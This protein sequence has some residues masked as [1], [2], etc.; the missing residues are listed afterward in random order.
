[1]KLLDNLIQIDREN[2]IS[3]F[4][5]TDEFF[6]AY[7]NK[8][9]N[10]SNRNILILT[11]TLYESNKIFSSIKN[12][13]D[14]A[15]FF[16][17]DDFLTNESIAMSPELKATR[18]DTISNLVKDKKSIVV[19]HLES[20]L[21]FLPSKKIFIDSIIKISVGDTYLRNDIVDKL[22]SIGYV[23][24]TIVTNTGEI[25]IRGFVIDV[26][27]TNMEYPIRIEFFDDI[28]ESIK[29]FNPETQK[30]IETIDTIEILPNTEFIR[31]SD[32]ANISE[33]SQKYLPEYCSD[34]SN[35]L[36]YMD[37]SIIV[38]KDKHQINSAYKKKCEEILEYRS[39]KDSNFKGR[40]M[41]ELSDFNL[42]N[43]ILY[44]TLDNKFVN[45]EHILSINYGVKKVPE[46]HENI[47]KINAYLEAQLLKK[48]TI[49]ICLKEFQVRSFTK[50]LSHKYILTDD[51]NI[52][53]ESINIINFPIQE[54][55]IY[56][57]YVFIT[58]KELFNK[59]ENVKYKQ[60][61][62]YTSKIKSINNIEIGDYVVHS[63]Y[64]ISVYNGIKTLTKQ[65]IKKDYLELLYAGT[66][67]LY[68]PVE[69]IEL[70]GKYTG[71]EGITPKITS[72]NSSEW[73]KTKLRVRNR[74]HDV[75]E[76][77][78]E[79]YAKRKL[80]RGFAFS[81]DDEL[82]VMFDNQFEFT[83]T[84]DQIR[85]IE[86]IKSDM[87]K[88]E[89][90]DR[91]LCGD[92]GYGKTE[93]AFRAMFK[94][95]NNSKQVFYLCPTTI[96]SNQQYESAKIRFSNFPVNIELINRFTSQKKIKQIVEDLSTGKIDILFGTHRLLSND[97]RP[98]DLGLLVIDEEQR[99][100]VVHKEKIKEYKENVDVLT[101]S[102]TPIPR[103]LQ[104]SLVGM[105]S[106]SLIETP[107]VDRYPIQTYVI[108]ENEILIR[109][110]IYKELGR[111]GQ[112]FVLYNNVKHIEEKVREIS[113]LVPE[114]KVVYTHGQLSK[115]ELEEKM[116][117]FIAHKYDIMVCTTIIETGIDINNV[118][119][120]IIYDADRFGLSQLYQIRGRVG[121]S[122]KIA[123]AY[124][125]Y[126]ENKILNETAVKRLQAI[127]EFTELGSGF[128][129]A[130]RD[131]AIRGAGDI[132]GSEQ[133]GFIDSVGIDLYLKILN[134]EVEKLR[135]N[136]VEEEQLT[137]SNLIEVETHISDEY[138]SDEE[139]KI[140]IHKL[141]NTINSYESLVEVKNELEDRFGKISENMKIYMYEE[142]FESMASFLGIVKANQNNKF[143]ELIF[144]KETSKK[145]DGEKLFISA[146]KLTRN[147][148][149]S[150]KDGCLRII[151]NLLNLD[152]HYIYYLTDLLSDVLANKF[153]LN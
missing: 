147:Y 29:I 130:S 33:Q 137:T 28:I 41:F 79:I 109:D 60:R 15:Y 103:T 123:Y 131:L 7:I 63:T 98:K 1:M 104:M 31:D 45:D 118:N 115:S 23:R 70:I 2:N 25:G 61:Y 151:L 68:V 88:T 85:A 149:F 19:C 87:E 27:P 75:A 143:I 53:D 84:P 92:V 62:K 64:G 46:F 100:G 24:Q 107:P 58:S 141:I 30:T 76:K 8:L 3:L 36:G 150:Y 93:V 124:L 127:K 125:M 37:N 66:D 9:F 17:M 129:I 94:A 111:K 6:C 146:M 22:I 108:E 52:F 12:Y 91:L 67:K 145:I 71:K 38:I 119:T 139:L 40:Y 144:D 96:L 56:G 122:N 113:Q 78:I 73:Q 114:A 97:I 112:V 81:K 65:G 152:K 128:S 117:D 110:A 90:M 47:E 42:S 4:G 148:S 99:F 21:R 54:G 10:S 49:I 48:N 102:A 20:F 39:I 105:R 69:K 13:N 26:F 82:Q 77:L 55:F 44:N 138:V 72:L 50:Y 32:N 121:R 126:K 83:E 57:S 86:Q 11:S 142:W 116:I 120:L 34:I 80:K 18:L 89:P 153:L 134:N 16:P 5:M 101:L 74:V 43:A 133:A 136:Y 95:V 135:G 140:E 51:E 14:N 35:I 132:L 59:N 106:L